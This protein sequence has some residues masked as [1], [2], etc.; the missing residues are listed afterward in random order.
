MELQTM[1]K[2]WVVVGSDLAID[3][4]KYIETNIVDKILGE[5][6]SFKVIE[7]PKGSNLALVAEDLCVCVNVHNNLVT[8]LEKLVNHFRPSFEAAGE[9]GLAELERLDAIIYE[10]KQVG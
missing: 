8:N 4:R 7:I 10:A 9:R 2:D 3:Q 6:V 1:N 5:N